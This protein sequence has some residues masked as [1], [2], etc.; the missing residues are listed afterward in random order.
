MNVKCQIFRLRTLFC[1]VIPVIEH[2][3][4]HRSSH[5]WGV[6]TTVKV[7]LKYSVFD[8]RFASAGDYKQTFI[9]L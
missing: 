8:V 9:F 6:G 4:I 3:H 1:S 7:K 5:T 2:N